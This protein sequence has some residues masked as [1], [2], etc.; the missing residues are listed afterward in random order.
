MADNYSIS[1]NP[2]RWLS[3][4]ADPYPWRA[5]KDQSKSELNVRLSKEFDFGRDIYHLFQ[6]TYD[7]Q[8]RYIPHIMSI[9]AFGRPISLV[10]YSADGVQAPQVYVYN[11]VLTSLLNGTTYNNSAVRE[12]NGQGVGKFLEECAMHGILQ[13]PDAHYN[14]IFFSLAQTSLGGLGIG[15]ESF[16]GGGRGAHVYD[17]PETAITFDNG[18]TSIFENFA[19]VLAPFGNIKNGSA[20]YKNWINPD[21][22]YSSPKLIPTVDLRKTLKED[23]EQHQDSEPFGSPPGYPKPV[24]LSNTF[25]IGGY[26]L[27]QSGY[28]DVAVLSVP[29]FLHYGDYQKVAYDF[30][31]K[32]KRDGKKKLVIDLS[33]NG[34]YWRY[35]EGRRLTQYQVAVRL[36]KATAYS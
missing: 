22:N 19:R 26:H 2:A 6:R 11:D 10:S 35:F 20:L 16:A 33:A 30:L 13:D 3:H 5:Q 27:N 14:N 18:T 12:I 8:F 7:G 25:L 28:E 9:F 21:D 32:A 34:W 29:S 23:L 4:A 31:D 24:A 17:G 36:W 15:T 1:E